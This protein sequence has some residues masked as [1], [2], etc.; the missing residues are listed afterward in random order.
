MNELEKMVDEL[1]PAATRM[2]REVALTM[3]H[4]IF[5]NSLYESVPAARAEIIRHLRAGKRVVWLSV[6]GAIVS[7][8]DGGLDRFRDVGHNHFEAQCSNQR[9]TIC[10]MFVYGFAGLSGLLPDSDGN[11]GEDK[12]MH[13]HVWRDVLN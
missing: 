3:A 2:E 13:G 6:E 5:W 4:E 7:R 12:I 9:G 8:P 10:A 1:F 11:I